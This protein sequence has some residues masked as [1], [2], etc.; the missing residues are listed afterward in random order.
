[1]AGGTALLTLMGALPV[2]ARAR[3]LYIATAGT[4]DG[5]FVARIMG[6]DREILA[7][8]DLPGR[9]HG[10]ATHPDGRE[11]IVFARR[12]GHYA[13]VVEIAGGAVRRT[14]HAVEGRHFYGHGAFSP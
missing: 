13:L 12:P 9:G 14:I 5:G 7:S 10:N 8:I 6:M 1:L 3:A 2:R 4:P 11:V